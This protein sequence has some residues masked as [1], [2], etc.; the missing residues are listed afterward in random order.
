MSEERRRVGLGPLT[1]PRISLP[2]PFSW[3]PRPRLLGG[4]PKRS[5]LAST[6]ASISES[7]LAGGAAAGASAA[8][9]K[10]ALKPASDV[11]CGA[12]ARAAS[13]STIHPLDT[14]KVRL[15][16]RSRIN[17]PV[18]GAPSMPPGVSKIG[19]LMPPT[20]AGQVKLDMNEL[21][22]SVASLYRVRA[23][24]TCQGL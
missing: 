6:S 3:L 8:P 9:S 22:R 10:V 20:G 24:G 14:L 1:L 12:L 13:Q 21:G 11:L 19:Q 18:P 15:Q 16:A 5:A 23:W 4:R 2:N 7:M 17:M